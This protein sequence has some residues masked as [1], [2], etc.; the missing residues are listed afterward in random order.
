MQVSDGRFDEALG[1]PAI[2][3]NATGRGAAA[4]SGGQDIFG[5]SKE[6]GSAWGENQP[7]VDDACSAPSDRP[8][9][10]VD[11][12]GNGYAVWQ[13]EHSGRSEIYFAYRPVAGDWEAPVPLGGSSGSDDRRSPAIAVDALGNATV[14][15]SEWRNHGYGLFA[16][17]RPPG[18]SWGAPVLVASQAG[19]W[20]RNPDIA[21]GP[22]GALV[23]VWEQVT[24]DHPEDIVLAFATGQAGGTWSAAAEVPGAAGSTPSVAADATGSVYLAWKGLSPDIY[25]SY[26]PAGGSWS[27][28]EPVDTGPVAASVGN[29]VIAADPAGNVVVVWQ[30]SRRDSGDWDIFAA[31]RT[32]AGLWTDNMR[33]DDDLGTA[34]QVMPAVTVDP[35]GNT[36]ALWTDNRNGD[37]DVE[38]A[39]RPVGGNWAPNLR[40]DDDPGF[41]EQTLSAI[42]V[43]GAG[44]AHV[45]WLDKRTGS[46]RL[47]F[48]SAHHRDITMPLR[49]FLSLILRH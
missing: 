6:P 7:I 15:W 2:A 38:F 21:A 41:A 1:S 29:P 40:V 48:S 43:D 33:V 44:N 27:S 30:D 36:Y 49:R 45:L 47:V 17:V 37:S 14:L 28:R 19:H 10:A 39:Y 5:A 16:A 42:A 12:A 18:G 20:L 13:D 35:A 46:S 32:T 23:A 4:W 25:F 31:D 34:N 9:L 11:G 24:P 8:D 22:A 26:R 3:V